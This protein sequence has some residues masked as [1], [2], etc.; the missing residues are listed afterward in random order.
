M[1]DY[2]SERLIKNGEDQEEE[3][4]NNIIIVEKEEK[5]KDMILHE[6]KKL[7]V[8]AA[9]AIFTRFSTFGVNVTSLAFIGHIGATEL[10]AYALIFTVLLRF[11]IGI[12]V[13]FQSHNVCEYFKIK[14]LLNIE[15]F[16]SF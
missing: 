13:S 8:V 16:Y 15:I 3:R 14:L 7:W 11:C 10:A 9:P 4:G 2:L 1:V 6:N 5:L 12:L